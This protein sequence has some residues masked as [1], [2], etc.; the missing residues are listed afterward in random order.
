MMSL[1]VCAQTASPEEL[2]KAVA[3]YFQ[4]YR[5]ENYQP[6]ERMALDHLEVNDDRGELHI[7]LNESFCSQIVTPQ[8]LAK[9]EKDITPHTLRHS[10]AAHL[11]ENGADLRSI[12]EMLGHSDISSTQVYAQLVRQNLKLVYNKYHPKA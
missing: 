3:A 5:C 6:V 11:L 10:F 9:I 2:T 4:E 1:A 7:F 12:Q 8:V